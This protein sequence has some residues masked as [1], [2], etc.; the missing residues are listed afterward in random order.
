MDFQEWSFEPDIC[1]RGLDHLT[2]PGITIAANM[3]TNLKYLYDTYADTDEALVLRIGRDDRG[4]Y[5]VLNQT[6]FY[7]QGGGQPADSGF[8]QFDQTLLS[9]EFVGFRDGEVLHYVAEEPPGFEALVGQLCELR[10]NLSRRLEHA[11]LHTGGHLIAGIIERQTPDVTMRAVKGFHFSE[12]AYVEFEGKAEGDVDALL[13]DVQTRIDSLIRQNPR[14][15]SSLMTYEELTQHCSNIPSQ[16]PKDKPLRIVTIE[17]LDSVPCG[18][19]HISTLSELGALRL[20]KIRSKKGHTKVS[21]EIG[22]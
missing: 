9:I 4:S 14:I 16:L 2:F 13:A 8:I 18:G 19:T 20:L 17:S 12:G 21:Y 5:L 3:D 1:Y 15:T 7:P 10:V 6:I 22:N 11:K